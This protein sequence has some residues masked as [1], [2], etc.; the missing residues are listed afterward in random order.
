MWFL[1]VMG[2]W[3]LTC[4]CGVGARASDRG[5]LRTSE[6]LAGLYDDDVVLD[7]GLLHADSGDVFVAIVAEGDDEDFVFLGNDNSSYLTFECDEVFWPQP[8]LKSTVLDTYA[9]SLEF[10]K[11]FCSSFVVGDVVCD[12]DILEQGHKSDHL[13]VKPMYRGRSPVRTLARNLTCNSMVLA[14]G[15][16]Y[17]KIGWVMCSA[18]RWEYA[19]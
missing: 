19:T 8:T 14:Y 10:F 5:V 4:W 11:E 9:I 2:D 16:L 7:D 17:L 15:S 6:V 13:V 3:E 1:V 12:D 18:F